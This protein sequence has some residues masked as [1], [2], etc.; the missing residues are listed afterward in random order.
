MGSGLPRQPLVVSVGESHDTE[1]NKGE[2]VDGRYLCS[3]KFMFP[4]DFD[5]NK[6]SIV[7]R[8]RSIDI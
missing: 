4:D 1:K 8:L 3:I 6:L 7:S 2:F 5:G